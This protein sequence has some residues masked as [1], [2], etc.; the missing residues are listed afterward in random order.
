[1]RLLSAIPSIKF[2]NLDICTFVCGCGESAD[3]LMA[4][5]E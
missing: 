2:T 4:R 5:K 3:H 1:M